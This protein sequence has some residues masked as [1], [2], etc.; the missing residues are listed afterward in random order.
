MTHYFPRFVLLAAILATL[1]AC[2]PKSSAPA[3]ASPPVATVN[4]QV[5]TRDFFEFYA[6][7]AT[8][9]T[10]AEL[11]PD[12]RNRLLDNLIKA[13]LVAQEASRQGIDKSGDSAYLLELSRLNVLEQAVSD[14]YLKDKKP[15]DAEVRSEYETEVAGMPKTEYHARH[16]LVAT[17]PFAEKVIQRLDRGEKFEDLAKVESMDPSK[18]NGGDIGWLRGGMP[19]EIMNALAG[20]KP[21]EYAKKPV[22]TQ[23]GWHILQLVESRPL[24]P[25][26]FEQAKPRFE[27]IVEA[28]KFKSYMDELMRDAKVTKT[29]DQPA[30]GAAASAAP[31]AT[32]TPSAQSVPASAPAAP[33][34]P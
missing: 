23:Y 16:I 34:K 4:G 19:P 24:T 25:P 7:T 29:L 27:Q 33:A 14:R 31:A 26:P 1:C 9:K 21:G 30:P 3:D 32:A 10:S 2:Q 28:K 6:K 15:T 22:Q 11:T 18:N 13:E 5:I 20:L 12:I 17:E 8:G